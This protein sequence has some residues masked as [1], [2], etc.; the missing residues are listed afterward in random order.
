MK[1]GQ[2]HQQKT[3]TTAEA[4]QN[5]SQG[6]EIYSNYPKGKGIKDQMIRGLQLVP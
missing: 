6:F 4:K 1:N 5:M 3:A 2:G